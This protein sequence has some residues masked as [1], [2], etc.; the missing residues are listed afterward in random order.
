MSAVTLGGSLDQIPEDIRHSSRMSRGKREVLRKLYV[1]MMYYTWYVLLIIMLI[2][3]TPSSIRILMVLYIA[4]FY[5]IIL[6][7]VTYIQFCMD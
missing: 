2:T 3:S 6:G 5:Y 7:P 4:M 1:I